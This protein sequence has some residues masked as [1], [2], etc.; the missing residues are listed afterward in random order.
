ML[1]EVVLHD[2]VVAVRVNAD[3]AVAR[4]CKFHHVAEDAVRA[5]FAAY[6]VDYVVGEGVVEPLTVENL[7]VGGFRRRQKS[8]ISHDLP[9]VFNH[10]T[11]L[12]FDVVHHD[13]HRRVAVDPLFPVARSLHFLPCLVEDWHDVGDVRIGGGTND[14]GRSVLH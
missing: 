7:L 5:V 14:S 4:E 8:E 1:G 2:D 3:V 9:V 10:E 12:L 13:L 11:A 6:A